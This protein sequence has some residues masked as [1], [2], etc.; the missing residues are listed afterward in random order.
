MADGKP[1]RVLVADSSRMTAQLIADSLRRSRNPRLEVF[2]PTAFTSAET[3]REISDRRPDVALVSASLNDGP[4]AGYSVLR[5]L[6]QQTLSTKTVLL[7][8]SCERD[9]VT[10]AFRAGARGVFVRS[11]PSSRLCRCVQCIYEGQIWAGTR[12]LEHLVGAV[13]SAKPLRVMNAK[14]RN[15]L[16]KRED[17]VV[18]LVA[19]GLSNREV[20][21]R[22]KLSEHTVKSYLFNIF[23]KV[24][25]SS[26]VELVLY[27]LSESRSEA[28]PS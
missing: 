10:D 13:A 11:E 21:E 17:E 18:A 4:F 12:E 24:G 19:D 27:A 26:R 9:L 2:L 20:S 6:Q 15:L 23:E 25:V 7:L 22:L 3:T 28:D 16:S 1:I 5:N 8:E 14:R